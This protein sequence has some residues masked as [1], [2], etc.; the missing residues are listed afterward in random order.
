MKEIL[1]NRAVQLTES[2]GQNFLHDRNRL[3]RI[4]AAARLSKDEKFWRLD[5]GWVR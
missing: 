5:R 1:A 4:V 3:Q 2:L